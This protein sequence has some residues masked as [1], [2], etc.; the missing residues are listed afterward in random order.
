MRSDSSI[1][2]GVISALVIKNYRP[3]VCLAGSQL[4]DWWD[5]TLTLICIPGMTCD[6]PSS[7]I[8]PSVC[9]I[10]DSC[11]PRNLDFLLVSGAVSPSVTR[12]PAP[13]S[14]LWLGSFSVTPKLWL[15][16]IPTIHLQS[17]HLQ[18]MLHVTRELPCDQRVVMLHEATM[19]PGKSNDERDGYHITKD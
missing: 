13:V 9:N 2:R 11:E 8:S 4:S 19:T 18:L 10:E 14:E 5:W 3:L 6:R 17:L 1:H 16:S 7:H 12:K 15:T